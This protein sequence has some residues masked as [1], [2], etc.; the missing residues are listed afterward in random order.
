M[1]STETAVMPPDDP[2]DHNR[3]AGA[4]LIV[5]LVQGVV[6]YLLYLAI[7]KH[8]R[9]STNAYVM[10]PL[11]MVPVFVPLL[12]VQA[13]GTVRLRTLLLW[14]IAAT[15][16]L[17][18]LGW[19]DIWRQW[20]SSGVRGPTGG[21]GEMT[22]AMV[23]FTVVGLFIA[24]SLITAADIERRYVASYSAYFEMAWKLEI[25]LL[26][27]AVFV[28]VF[29][30]VLWLGAVL[31]NLIKL[32]FI[33]TIIEKPWFA[34]PVSALA[35][36]AA[37]HVTDVRSRLIAGVR[38]VVHTLLSW[39]LPLMVLIA[40]GFTVSLPFTGLQPLWA[41][42]SAAGLLLTAADVLVI[43]I[44]AAYQDGDP[45]HNKAVVMRWSEFAAAVVLIP[46]VLIAAYALALRVNQYGWTVER[47]LMAAT[48][49]VA[50]T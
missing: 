1:A 17:A 10:A 40:V 27:S 21:D 37:L 9:P 14:T 13:V 28:G 49:M 31:F 33:E 32:D 35:T 12:F 24:Q 44:N 45:Q 26:L 16:L 8:A 18:L 50:R 6:L 11:L 34:I 41:T 30:G 5:G 2:A 23:A 22:F 47:I 46:F 3:L 48:T 39:L 36:A 19:L 4:R 15:A 38:T 7:D 43:L 42:K 20:D 25:Q 29:W